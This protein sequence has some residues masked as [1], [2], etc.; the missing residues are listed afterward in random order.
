MVSAAGA[1]SSLRRKSSAICPFPVLLSKAGECSAW[2]GSHVRG[3]RGR[4]RGRSTLLQ[5]VSWLQATHK[6]ANVRGSHEIGGLAALGPQHQKET[7]AAGLP[8]KRGGAQCGKKQSPRLRLR[9]TPRHRVN[10]R[11][12]I[13][14]EWSL[15]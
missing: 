11:L 13:R 8:N 2:R 5:E 14:E 4:K 10:H 1:A 6:E 12:S 7:R 9:S 3:R 15:R